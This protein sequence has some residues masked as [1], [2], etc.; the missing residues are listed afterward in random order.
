MEAEAA[1]M[2]KNPR[3]SMYVKKLKKAQ[4]SM[5]EEDNSQL[6][7]RINALVNDADWEKIGRA[8]CRERV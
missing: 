5:R 1:G 8:S 3:Y 4:K 6:Y 2:N 7:Q